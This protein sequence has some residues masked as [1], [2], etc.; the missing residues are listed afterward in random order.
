MATQ[1]KTSIA[2]DVPSR[3]VEK[4]SVQEVVPPV[5][6]GISYHPPQLTLN[7]AEYCYSELLT[8]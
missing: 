4:D 8:E 7:K 5:E 1:E 2:G 6:Q 3:D